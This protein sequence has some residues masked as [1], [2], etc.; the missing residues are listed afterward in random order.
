MV[1]WRDE[2]G[3]VMV[4]YALVLALLSLA[5]VSGMKAIE[6]AAATTLNS[7]SSELTQYGLRSGQ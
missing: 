2:Q 3:A 1:G 5:V 7:T 4:E 6:T